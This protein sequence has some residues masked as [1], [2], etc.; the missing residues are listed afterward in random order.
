MELT[1]NYFAPARA[2]H[3]LRIRIGVGHTSRAFCDTG[4]GEHASRHTCRCGCS[5][6]ALPDAYIHAFGSPAID[7]SYFGPTS[8]IAD[9]LTMLM[10]VELR[11]ETDP[12]GA[13]T[14]LGQAFIS[15]QIPEPGAAGLALLATG[16][17]VLGRRRR[18]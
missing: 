7:G 14:V 13:A 12:T 16:A 3:Y 5:G 18:A 10:K 6:D 9:N 17:A 15:V 2:P 11:S 1:R 4:G 8:F